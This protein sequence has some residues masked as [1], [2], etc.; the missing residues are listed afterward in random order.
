MGKPNPKML[1]YFDTVKKEMIPLTEVPEGF[2][3]QRVCGIRDKIYVAA[4]GNSSTLL[5]YNPTSKSWKI[6]PSFDS[7]EEFDAT[8][9]MFCNIGNKLYLQNSSIRH[10]FQTLDL[11]ADDPQWK[12]IAPPNKIYDGGSAAVSDDCLYIVGG[13]EETSI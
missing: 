3:C 10:L 9:D 6:L 12:Q 5:E 8:V 13:E 11:E 7:E 2:Q 1:S 4:D